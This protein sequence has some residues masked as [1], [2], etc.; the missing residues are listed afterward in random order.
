M[1]I[2]PWR[3]FIGIILLL[4]AFLACR[5][6][7]LWCSEKHFIGSQKSELKHLGW[8]LETYAN[9]HGHLPSVLNR[10]FIHD[11]YLATQN[12]DRPFPPAD[13]DLIYRGAGKTLKNLKPDEVILFTRPGIWGYHPGLVLCLM[14][15]GHVEK[16]QSEAATVEA[17][18]KELQR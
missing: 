13:P 14:A 9:E 15:D 18:E 8:S 4:C 16:R 3:A 7:L 6:L 2:T 1:A 5:P 17:F 10:D 11:L 12:R